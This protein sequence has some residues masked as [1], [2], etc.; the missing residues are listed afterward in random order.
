V[1][2]AISADVAAARSAAALL[3]PEAAPLVLNSDELRPR[4]PLRGPL[5]ERLAATPAGSCVA[6]VVP[7]VWRGP[8]GAGPRT[9]L[10]GEEPPLVAVADHLNLE[11]RGPLTGPWPAGVPRTFPPLAGIYQPAVV[12][13]RGGPRVYSSGVVVAGVADAGRL[14]PF[15]ASVIR[16]RRLVAFADSLVPPVIAAAYYGLTVAAC[17][18]PQLLDNDEE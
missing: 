17:G 5:F 16:E 1:A 2:L 11:L 12:R 4:E 18:V 6:L 9:T 10:A 3:F 7:V 14:T 8:P 15:E 13:A